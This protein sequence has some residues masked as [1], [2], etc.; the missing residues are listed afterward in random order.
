MTGQPCRL[1]QTRLHRYDASTVLG[2]CEDC[3]V[4]RHQAVVAFLRTGT[5]PSPIQPKWMPKPWTKDDRKAQRAL[6]Q[7]RRRISLLRQQIQQSG[8]NP[9]QDSP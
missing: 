2:I 7:E 3:V 5:Q 8:K 4:Y 1:C 6:F 9:A